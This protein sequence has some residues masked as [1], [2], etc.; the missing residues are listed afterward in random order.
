METIRE[1][2]RRTGTI[3][4]IAV[5]CNF[6]TACE[7]KESASAPET[8]AE[9]DAAA[10][11]L[12]KREESRQAKTPPEAAPIS[13]VEETKPSIAEKPAVAPVTQL[14]K[15]S[16]KEGFAQRLSAIVGT[17]I[18]SDKELKEKAERGDKTAQ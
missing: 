17:T 3:F 7:K 15:D 1:H 8:N 5:L 10:R 13:V 4:L 9:S 6:A 16:S 14:P 2:V 12:A 11:W 18:A